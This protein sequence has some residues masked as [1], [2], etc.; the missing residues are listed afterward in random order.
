[1]VDSR[2]IELGTLFLIAFI[3]LVFV[4]N[5]AREH[6]DTTLGL[7][8]GIMMLLWLIGLVL[9]FNLYKTKK[10]EEGVEL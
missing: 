10:K 4:A 7:S 6:A 9:T 8:T 3:Y 1:M 2:N 5:A